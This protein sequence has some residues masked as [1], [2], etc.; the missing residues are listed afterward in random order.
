MR[1]KKSIFS[2]FSLSACIIFYITSC[3][4]G[5]ISVSSSA[6]PTAECISGDGC[7]PAEC[8][9]DTDSDCPAKGDDPTGQPPLAPSGLSALAVSSSA[10]D[11]AWTDNSDNETAFMLEMRTVDVTFSILT[12]LS[13]NTESY[14]AIGLEPDT[15][16]YFRLA[17]SNSSGNSDYSNETSATTLPQPVVDC[18]YY[19]SESGS[20]SNTG[21]DPQQAWQTISQVNSISLHAGESICFERGGTFRGTLALNNT[22]GT[23]QEP[24]V[25]SSYGSGN[26]PELKGSQVVIGAWNQ[27]GN[28]WSISSSSFPESINNVFV[29]Q[30][31]QTLGRYPK[32]GYQNI[33]SGSGDYQLSD[34]SLSDFPDNYWDGA[35]VAL[36]TYRWVLDRQIVQSHIGSTLTFAGNATYDVQSNYGYFLQNHKNCLSAEG[37]WAYDSSSKT[38][39]LYTQNDPSQQI[40]E[41]AA[42]DNAFDLQDSNQIVIENLKLTHYNL[43]TIYADGCDYLNINNCEIAYS[44]YDA[45]GIRDSSDVTV[46]TNTITNTNNNGINLSSCPNARITNNQLLDTAVIAGRGGAVNVNANSKLIGI[47]AR[48]ADSSLIQYNRIERVGYNGISFYYCDNITIDSNFISQTSTVTDDSGGIYSWSDGR[49]NEQSY[50]TNNII[51]EAQGNHQ[52][53]SKNYAVGD[54]FYIDDRSNN[55]LLEGNTAYRCRGSGIHINNVADVEIRNNTFFAL[56]GG[57]DE[58]DSGYLRNSSDDFDINNLTVEYNIFVSGHGATNDYPYTVI[59]SQ[60]WLDDSSNVLDNNYL[61]NGFSSNVVGYHSAAHTLSEWQNYGVEA[62]AKT[63]PFSFSDSGLSNEDDF[64]LFEYNASKANKSVNLPGSFRYFDIAGNPVTGPV[65][66]A[67]YESI[68]LLRKPI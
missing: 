33:S 53:T 11:I 50:V 55:I 30:V 25:F 65:T 1:R 24:I 35:E 34:S 6:C 49:L 3:S 39:Y 18:T 46:N 14:R 31:A 40:V 52:G 27:E 8:N 38:L 43:T 41:I 48:Y 36:K 16:Y 45:I 5:T 9:S 44:G 23:S 26:L 61:I 12:T 19:V 15:E 42:L 59:D 62:N 60:S 13:A 47:L 57:L 4:K 10:I 29:N 66:L 32:T 7:C 28:I 22:N 17:A 68:V 2:V 21:E 67:P 20:D 54:C 37:E 51:I 64:F 58:G 56:D 63:A